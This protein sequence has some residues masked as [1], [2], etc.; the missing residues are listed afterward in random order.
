MLPRLKFRMPVASFALAAALVSAQTVEFDA[1]R[2]KAESGDAKAQFD[3]ADA[4][5]EGK[6]VAK[7]STKGM[8]W[9]KRSAFKGYAGA[10]VV[11]GYMYQKGIN[12]EKDPSEAAKWYRKAARRGDKDLKHAQTA[13]TH[14]SEMLSEGLISAK[15]AD[16]HAAEAST[17]TP[18]QAKTNKPPP[19]SFGEVET[20]L[21][22]GITT[23][24][25]ETLVSMYGVDFTLSAGTR[26]RLTDEGA[27]E[28]L[29]A[30]I[31]SA[32]RQP[33]SSPP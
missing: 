6:G 10:Q 12:T 24:R 26:K 2:R 9:L 15:E 7:D 11:L 8:E 13:Q 22:G 3:L 18:K 25:M 29:L 14:L 33:H 31:A 1:L 4:Y 21:T 32:K 20:G 23:K 19:F 17:T 28:N 5:S 27:D 16:W 30:T